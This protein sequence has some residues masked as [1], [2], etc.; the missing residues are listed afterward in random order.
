MSLYNDA[1]IAAKA[2]ASLDYSDLRC[3]AYADGAYVN[4]IITNW[5][6]DKAQSLAKLKY[7]KWTTKERIKE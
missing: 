4:F 6:M 7:K 2:L 5:T 1:C 3:I